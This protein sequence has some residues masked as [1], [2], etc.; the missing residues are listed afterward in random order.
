MITVGSEVTIWGTVQHCTVRSA[1]LAAHL[2][3]EAA[4]CDLEP[5]L[6]EMPD[7]TTLVE[8]YA[9]SIEPVWN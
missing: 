5:E 1:R 3:E 8:F 7:G 4:R 2:Y 9:P 6:T